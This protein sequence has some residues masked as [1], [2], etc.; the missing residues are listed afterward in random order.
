MDKVTIN[1][2]GPRDGLQNIKSILSVD[3]RVSLIRSLEEAGIELIEIG[4]F[5]NDKAVPAMRNTDELISKLG[6]IDKYSVLI[7]NKK[8]LNKAINNGVKEI[9][10]VLCVTD[11]MNK[12]NINQTVE[13]TIKDLKEI[14]KE[15]NDSGMR[16]KCY[17]SVAYYCPYEGKVD[18]MYV[19]DV[20]GQLLDYKV[21]EIVIADTIG[22]A[23]PKE[24]SSL[25]SL[26]T[27]QYKEANFSCHFHDTRALGLANVYASLVEGINKFDACIGGLGGCP[28]APNSSGNLATE[29]LVSMLDMMNIKTGID[30]DK[31]INT[32][33]LASEF[34]HLSLK[35][36]MI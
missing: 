20:I 12:N 19:K 24:V 22:A 3:E 23:N 32:R 16:S 2:V 36:R 4:S 31:L 34:T 35:G 17:V 5:V 30:L 28:F 25:L 27:S 9:C 13:E 26:L 33:E 6:N 8:G 7:P 18:S 29:D 21:D 11:S 10:T 14:F 1:E 15:A